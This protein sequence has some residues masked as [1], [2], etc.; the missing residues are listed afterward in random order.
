MRSRRRKKKNLKKIAFIAF[1]ILIT[2]YMIWIMDYSRKCQAR[3]DEVAARADLAIAR[4]ERSLGI[5]R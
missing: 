4:A 1:A 2:G 3:A 5:G